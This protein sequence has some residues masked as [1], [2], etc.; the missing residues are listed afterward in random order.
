MEYNVAIVLFPL[1]LV[2]TNSCLDDMLGIELLEI[3]FPFELNRQQSR[4]TQLTNDTDHYIAFMTISAEWS[5]F[6]YSLQP[7]EGIVPARGGSRT[8][9]RPGLSC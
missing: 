8:G 4:S 1:L 3:H 9:L 5:S 2:Q 6:I 7:D